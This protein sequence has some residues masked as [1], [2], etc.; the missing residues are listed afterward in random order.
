MSGVANLQGDEA[1]KAAAHNDSSSLSVATAE[2]DTTKYVFPY[3]SPAEKAAYLE[4]MMDDV[5]RQ[6]PYPVDGDVRD[7]SNY[8]VGEIALSYGISSSG[9]RTYS[10]PIYTAPDIKYAPALFWVYNS[11]G[12]YGYGGYGWD[13][14]GLSVITLTQK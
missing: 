1:F 13:I 6:K 8:S 3:K 12:G 11:Q 9:A 5:V 2:T 4:A 7:V 14:G 10:I